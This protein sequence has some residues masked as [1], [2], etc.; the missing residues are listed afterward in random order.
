MVRGGFQRRLPRHAKLFALAV[1]VAFVTAAGTAPTAVAG[2]I[3]TLAGTGVDGFS[4]DGGPANRAQLFYPVGVAPTADGGVLIADINNDRVRRVSASGRIT[5]VAG[6]GESA[7][8]GDGGPATAAALNSPADVEPT[9][10]GGFLV[11]DGENSRIRKVSAAGIITTVAGNGSRVASGDGGPATAA[12]FSPTFIALTPDGGY[13]I[14]DDINDQVRK[15]AAN[16]TIRTVAGTGVAG[17]SGDGGPATAAMLL[18][19][20]GL[21]ATPDGSF[22]VADSFNNRVRRVSAAGIITT[23]A[24]TGSRG[25]SGDGGPATRAQLHEP[26]GLAPTADGG[27]LVADQLNNRIRKI[28]A[29]GTITTVAG[30]GTPQFY[31]DGGPPRLASIFGPFDVASTPDGGYLIADS[32]N[33]RIRKVAPGPD[34]RALVCGAA[35]GTPR[36]GHT[37]VAARLAGAVFLKRP[38]GR[39]VRLRGRATVPM[40]STVD[41]TNGRVRL[42]SA[43]CRPG[44]T[45]RGVFDGGAFRVTQ[46]SR[47]AETSLRLTGLGG[48]GGTASIARR[49]IRRLRGNAR[50]GYSIG[51]RY[52]NGGIHHSAELVEDSCQATT[53]V[54]LEGEIV[55]TARG[56]VPRTETLNPGD[57]VSAFCTQ[58]GP[59]AVPVYCLRM[60]QSADR[61]NTFHF[62]L[63]ANVQPGPSV[64]KGCVSGGGLSRC[65]PEQLGLD[66]GYYV[67]T[68]SCSPRRAGVVTGRWRVAGRLLG[69]L[70]TARMPGGGR[71]TCTETFD[72]P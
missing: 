10:D 53:V 58:R 41:A 69:T 33:S 25:F 5:T 40:G 7:F 20:Q 48:C 15:V 61:G 39:R 59:A 38:R 67:N 35:R 49:R 26:A 43:A 55:A 31:G 36:V 45:R 32:D 16:G 14:S 44:S 57:R 22:L 54:A 1:S 12:G 24:G 6:I 56:D 34:P 70:Q 9:P 62:T 66:A 4:G 18:N 21:L 47:T 46:N 42:V 64:F 2:A 27:V 3:T 17:F 60:F 28:A 30:D 29:D 65:F 63:A 19:P 8:S 71:N 23:V 50:G 37:V 68:I 11:A 52:V 51:G 13:L 72:W